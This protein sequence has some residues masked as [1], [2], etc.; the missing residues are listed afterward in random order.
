M[1]AVAALCGLVPA[2]RIGVVA[3]AGLFGSLFESAL[4]DLASLRGVQV[5]HEFA[6]AFTTFVGAAA[7]LELALC[8]DARRLYLPFGGP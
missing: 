6:N 8:L 4:F 2:A 1:G 5:D 3:V 7:A